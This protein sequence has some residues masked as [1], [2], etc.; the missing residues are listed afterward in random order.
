MIDLKTVSKM[1]SQDQRIHCIISSIYISKQVK[2][3]H[4]SGA[5]TGVVHGNE[6]L[7]AGQVASELPAFFL[8]EHFS[9]LA[10]C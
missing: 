7:N 10:L 9:Q 2:L 6:Q 3:I 4:D 5:N 8:S 1:V